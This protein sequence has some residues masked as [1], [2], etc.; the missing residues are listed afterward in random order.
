M[1]LHVL[2]DKMP[3]KSYSEAPFEV[4]IYER[5]GWNHVHPEQSTLNYYSDGFRKDGMTDMGI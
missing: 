3:I 5:E 1:N 4:K 2:S